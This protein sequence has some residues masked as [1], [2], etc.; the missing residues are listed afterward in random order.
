MSSQMLLMGVGSRRVAARGKHWL[1]L[2]FGAVVALAG[3]WAP[4]QA[5]EVEELYEA[6]VP[7]PTQTRESWQSAVK[8]ALSEV[9]VRVTGNSDVLRE[10]G[11]G[12]LVAQAQR[13]VQ[14]FRYETLPPSASSGT[15]GATPAQSLWV[16]FDEKALTT[17][18]RE[19]G[20]AAWG[21]LRAPA[22]VWLAVDDGRERFLLASGSNHE[23]VDLM[24]EQARRRGLPLRLPLFDLTDRSMVRVSDVWGNFSD[25]ILQA[26]KRYEVDAVLVGRVYRER[27]GGWRGYWH[28]YQ[29]DAPAGWESVGGSLAE[30][31]DSGIDGT[32]KA[33]AKRFAALGATEGT[34]AV[35]VRINDVNNVQDYARVTSYLESLASVV[36]VD[37]YI[38]EPTAV[39]YRVTTRGGSSL[40]AHA[41][42]LGSNLAA[43]AADAMSYDGG[44]VPVVVDPSRVVADLNYRLLP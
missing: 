26:S 39:L 14:Q 15:D 6:R 3:A 25:P 40:L 11:V 19:L 35:L 44:T 12:E 43:E 8:A 38:V 5:V 16:R 36:R 37:P 9:I 7:V 21:R 27:S 24:Q 20:V 10:Q 42:S 23:A 41:I 1:G 33:M 32:T 30:V 4:A 29:V 18:L 13:F 22:L 34:A 31:L 28:L 17:R 2:L